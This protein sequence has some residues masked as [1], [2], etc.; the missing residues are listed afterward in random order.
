VT[1]C[2]KDLPMRPPAPATAIL[3]MIIASLTLTAVVTNRQ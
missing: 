3:V 1:A 2:T